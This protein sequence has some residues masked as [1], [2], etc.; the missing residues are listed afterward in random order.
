GFGFVV[1]YRTDQR[2]QVLYFLSGWLFTAVAVMAKG[3]PGL[4]IPLVVALAYPA[5]TGRFRD[6]LRMQ[7]LALLVLLLIIV[8][9]WYLQMYLRHGFGFIERLILHDMFKRAF[10]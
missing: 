8:G 4:V 9:P 1:W 10:V 6:L 5:L 7:P 3:A 2:R